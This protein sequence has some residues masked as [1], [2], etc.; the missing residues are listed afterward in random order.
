[1][2]KRTCSIDGCDGGVDAR[3]WCSKHWKRWRNHGD[4]LA[5]HQ[6]RGANP[7]ACV[8]QSGG[9]D[10]CWPWT[11]TTDREGYGVFKSGRRHHRA[12]RWVL[13]QKLG[14]P[15]RG[16]EKTRHTCDNKIC[17]NPAHLIPGTHADNTRDA[18]ERARVRRG[19]GH[20]SARVTAEQV[21]KIRRRYATGGV[22][23]QQL[24]EQY[25]LS[26]SEIGRVIRRETWAHLESEVA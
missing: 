8:D 9:P 10:S 3:G 12:A 11:F 14:R 18:V 16:T 23:H 22:T 24:A 1:M 7:W 19:E 17:C 4:P 21:I 26:P 15:L 6:P 13:Q 20:G 5:T 25:H 2:T